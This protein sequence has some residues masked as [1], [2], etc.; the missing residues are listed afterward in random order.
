MEK[1]EEMTSKNQVEIDR[2]V[3]L[4]KKFDE[5]YKKMQKKKALNKNLSEITGSAA[6]FMLLK[7]RTGSSEKKHY[8]GG[9]KRTI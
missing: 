3:A 1:I 6:Q 4:S 7:Q 2:E 5:D 9:Q 8:Q